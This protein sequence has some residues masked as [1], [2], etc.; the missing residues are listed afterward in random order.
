MDVTPRYA[1]RTVGFAGNTASIAN[2]SGRHRNEAGGWLL[3][4][5]QFPLGRGKGRNAPI[6]VTP[7]AWRAG[8]IEFPALQDRAYERD[9]SARKRF[10]AEGVRCARSGRGPM[11]QFRTRLQLALVRILSSAP[12]P[13]YPE[14]AQRS[15]SLIGRRAPQS[16]RRDQTLANGGWGLAKLSRLPQASVTSTCCDLHHRQDTATVP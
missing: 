5:R 6:A 11:Q 16:Y 1:G 3:P 8:Q 2:S 9:R 12:S 13:F 7:A 10:S 14:I 4:K 15:W